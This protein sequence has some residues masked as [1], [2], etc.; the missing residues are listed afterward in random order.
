M[1]NSSSLTVTA[2]SVIAE[3]SVSEQVRVATANII[4]CAFNDRLDTVIN[5]DL[6]I[7][8]YQSIADKVITLNKLTNKDTS[9]ATECEIDNWD[10]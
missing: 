1:A 7:K 8:Y 3:S 5:E 2:T 6:E 9:Y 10:F 4:V